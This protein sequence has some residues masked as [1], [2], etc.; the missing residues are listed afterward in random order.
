MRRVTRAPVV[1]VM[2]AGQGTRMKS[3]T[4][5]VLHDLLGRPMGLWPVR[6][7]LDAGAQKVVVVDS[8][9][10]PLKAHLPEGAVSV[11]QPRGQRDR[12]RG[13]GC[14]G[15]H[16]PRR[17]GRGPQRRR[18]ARQRRRDRA[19]WSRR[20]A[21]QATMAT[22]RLDDPTGYGRVVRRADGSVEK[23]V[24][25]KTDGD[26]TA[27][28]LAIDEVNTGIYAFDGAFLLDTLPKLTADNA[29]GELYLPQVLD[30]AEHASAPTRST[31][32]TWSS[33]STTASRWPRS[34]RSRS[35]RCSNGLMRSGVT[36]ID[37]AAT[38]VDVGVTRR[39][40]HDARA[41]HRPARRDDDRRRLPHR[42]ARR[43]DR[44]H[45]RG[46][47]QRRAVRLPAP[48]HAPA[49]RARRSARSS[50]SRTPTSAP[51]P[52]SRTF[53]TSAT[54]T[55]ARTPTSAPRRSPPTTTPRRRPRAARRS[56]TA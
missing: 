19:P 22:T 56:A 14:R 2:A 45:D 9:D 41:R 28:E 44:R 36:V 24:E 33:A 4:P 31:T 42:P 16:R 51:A 21:G 8:P 17:A 18:A 34:A 7:A 20:T 13:A 55:S 50:R 48:G 26:A 6:A 5:K 46:R 30:H 52:R 25:T 53:A 29:Q 23:V 3:K 49:R 15:A 37:P 43:R 39:P 10:E 11:V 40:G 54:P 32:R 47:R 38:Y 12:R 1:I 27:E 35:A